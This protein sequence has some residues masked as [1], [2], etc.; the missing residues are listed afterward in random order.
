MSSAKKAVVS[1]IPLIWEEPE[2]TVQKRLVIWL[3]GFGGTKEAVQPYL[4]DLAAR[5]FVALSYDPYQHGERRIESQ[6]ELR[7]RVVGNIRRHFWPILTRTAEE[8][9]T[10]VDWAL[11]ELDI[12]GTVGMGGISMGDRKSVV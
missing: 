1:E 5:G 3:P 4:V 6:E 11:A 2:R 7:A 10:V 8:V 9:S 12:A